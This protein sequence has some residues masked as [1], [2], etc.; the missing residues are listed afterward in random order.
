MKK[1]ILI[2]TLLLT[3][4]ACSS[5]ADLEI[6][7]TNLMADV[8]ESD[9]DPIVIDDQQ[10]IDADKTM[11]ITNFSLDILDKIHDG[12]NILIS[13]LSLISALSMTANGAENETLYQMEEVFGAD[14]ESLNEYLY[15]YMS[16]IPSDEKYKVS[17]ANAIWF[18]DKEGLIIEEDFLQINKD[19]YDAEVYKGAFDESTKND[20]NAWVNKKTDGM[21]EELLEDNPPD[22]AIMYLI[23]ALS[24]D[25]EWENIYNENDIREDDFTSW[26]GDVETVEFMY[27]EEYGYIEIPNAIGFSKPYA[28]NKYSFVALLPDE[29]I[30][31]SDFITSMDSETLIDAIKNQSK[32]EVFTSMPKFEFEY[33]NELSKTLVE[34]GMV[35][36]FDEELADFTS[37]GHSVEGNILINRVIHKTKIQ[38]DE[39]GTKAGAATAVEMI[40]ETAAPIEPKV[41]N[42]NR[43]FFFVIVDNEHSM[44]IFMGILNEVT[45]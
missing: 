19:Y 40:E 23:N 21:I 44:P 6:V 43:P 35:D 20:I 29:E 4:T 25:A 13:P 5:N 28:D 16:Y 36:A 34:L 18:K 17:L 15:S 8:K 39:K 33:D 38:M 12:E 32:E 27:S 37:L 10:N 45:E 3:L 42:L 9:I 11:E 14:R 7:S 24:F 1:I 41:V 31:V 26:N 30:E 2:L 22:E